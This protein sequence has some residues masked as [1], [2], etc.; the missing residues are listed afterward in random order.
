[1]WCGRRICLNKADFAKK[2]NDSQKGEDKTAPTQ[3]A[4]L[5]DDPGYKPSNEFKI[6]LAAMC[7][8]DDYKLLENQF[9]SGN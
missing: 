1:M 3:K 5:E 9:F 8:E 6:A 2:L 4:R 7:S